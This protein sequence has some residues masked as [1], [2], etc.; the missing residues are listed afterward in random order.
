MRDQLFQSRG[1]FETAE[2]GD[3]VA[4]GVTHEGG[5]AGNGRGTGLCFWNIGHEMFID[6]AVDYW[7]DKMIIMVIGVTLIRQG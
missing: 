5:I 7:C 3:G 2:A 1:S 4:N 6:R